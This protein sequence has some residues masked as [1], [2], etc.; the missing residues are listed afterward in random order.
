MT[1]WHYRSNTM[2]TTKNITLS[3]IM[4]AYNEAQ[5]IKENLLETSHILGGFLHNYEI[6]AV[7][8][9]STD[10]TASLIKEAAVEDSHIIDAGYEDNQ[11]KGHAITTGIKAASG[12]YI[13]FLD[14]DLELSPAL[15]KPFLKQMKQT[16]ADIV[17]G[18]KLHPESKLDYPPM[19]RFMSYSY[20]VML[21][22]LFHLGIH[23]TQTGIKLFKSEV[24]KPIAENLSIS[25]YAFDIE[26]LVAAH[27]KG[28]TI[29]E[30][31]IVLNYSRDDAADGRRIK[32]KDILKVFSDTIAIKNKYK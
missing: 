5:H 32:I 18:S 9:G 12:T 28:Y 15:L 22:I 14:S 24:I 30:A 16:D 19:R 20:Y 7:N 29:E 1:H 23:D 25:G 4:P 31:P 3:V 21:K 8:D 6:I 11:G 10:A 26:I 17:I 13:A 27:S 2:N